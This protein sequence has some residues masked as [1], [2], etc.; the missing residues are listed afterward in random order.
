MSSAFMGPPWQMDWVD[1]ARATRDSLPRQVRE[2]IDAAAD[3]QIII[4]EVFW[5]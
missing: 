5:Q 4:E 2:L 1:T 3:P